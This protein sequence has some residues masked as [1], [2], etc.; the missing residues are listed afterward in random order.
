MPISLLKNKYTN[1]LKDYEQS[2]FI[3][4][5]DGNKSPYRADDCKFLLVGQ[6]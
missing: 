1:L 6:N 2:L 3:S 4:P 5:L